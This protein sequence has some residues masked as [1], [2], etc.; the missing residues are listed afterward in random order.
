MTGVPQDPARVPG[1]IP[2]P[3]VSGMSLPLPAQQY[4][5]FSSFESRG[6]TP[7][8]PKFN[9]R[10]H[11]APWYAQFRVVAASA[12]WN[13]LEKAVRVIVALE[14]GATNIL[15]GL[16]DAQMESF[17]GLIGRLK[18]RYDPPDR[19]TMYRTEFTAR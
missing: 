4:L 13:T 6:R 1:V 15:H 17:E 18:N 10:G 9:G 16:S 8:V 19:E 14:G 5:D 11:F 12:G 2:P 7:K 3:M